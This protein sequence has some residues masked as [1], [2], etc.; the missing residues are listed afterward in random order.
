MPAFLLPLL[1]FN[2][3]KSIYSYIRAKPEHVLTLYQWIV[4]LDCYCF[5][6]FFQRQTNKEKS[7]SIDNVNSLLK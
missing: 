5:W 6:F 1:S 4:R 3:Y 7:L 2:A